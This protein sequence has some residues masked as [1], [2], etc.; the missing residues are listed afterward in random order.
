MAEFRSDWLSKSVAGTS[1]GFTLAVA[2]A[3]LFAVAGPGGLEARNK[4]QFVMWLI[5]PIW[6][7]VVSLVFLFRSGRAA[8]LWLGGANLLA[9]GGLYLCRRFLH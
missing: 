6:L 2:L 4:Y 1:L 5:A 8:F 9:F 3:G 7:G